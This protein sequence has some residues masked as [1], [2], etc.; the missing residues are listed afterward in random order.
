MET[1]GPEI[2]MVILKKKHTSGDSN[3]YTTGEHIN[4]MTPLEK[5]VLI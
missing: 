1:K 4:C 3:I 5:F 2:A